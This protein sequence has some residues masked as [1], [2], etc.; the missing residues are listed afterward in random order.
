MSLVSEKAEW[1]RKRTE[2]EMQLK[3]TEGDIQAERKW[4]N[5]KMVAVDNINR[6]DHV[7]A[8]RPWTDEEQAEETRHYQALQSI[9]AKYK[10]FKPNP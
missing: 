6:I 9:Y 3:R 2:A 8:I 5:A 4:S 7:L 1:M 10:D